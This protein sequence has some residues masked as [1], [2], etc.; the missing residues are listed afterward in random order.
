[1]KVPE[2]EYEVEK[3]AL[4]DDIRETE[5]RQTDEA[6]RITKF[7]GAA[8]PAQ[9]FAAAVADNPNDDPDR[10]AAKEAAKMVAYFTRSKALGGLGATQGGAQIAAQQLGQQ[11]GF[12]IT[13]PQIREA[14]VGVRR[15]AQAPTA[16]AQRDERDRQAKAQAANRQ[17]EL[18]QRAEANRAGTR[19]RAKIVRPKKGKTRMPKTGK[20]RMPKTVVKLPDNP[21]PRRAHT[22]VE[23]E[24]ERIAKRKAELAAAPKPVEPK[25]VEPKPVVVAAPKPAPAPELAAAQKPVEPKPVEPKPAVVAPAGPIAPKP[26]VAVAIPAGPIAAKPIV[27]APAPIALPAPAKPPAPKPVF[28]VSPLIA[29]ARAADEARR[30]AAEERQAKIMRAPAPAPVAIPAVPAAKPAAVA[31]V[32]LVKPPAKA[33]DVAAK[34]AAAPAPKP[35]VVMVPAAPAAKPVVVMVPAAPAAKPVVVMVPAAPAATPAAAKPAPPRPAPPAAPAPAPP[36][37]NRELTE[38]QNQLAA[39]AV[40]AAGTNVGIA[41]QTLA[42]QGNVIAD[43][44]RIKGEQAEMKRELQRQQSAMRNGQKRGQ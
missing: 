41:Q 6:G 18:D 37:L 26:I 22:S 12:R 35:V 42:I 20:T 13:I 3:K 15:D 7:V 43:L 25:P 23:I 19:S 30:T 39:Q 1:V 24:N 27:A 9:R 2:K 32:A 40:A 44:Q 28:V 11:S 29:A 10:I 34:P 31:P 16:A 33:A 14:G 21:D 36:R 4:E 5:K 8:E 17:A 38:R